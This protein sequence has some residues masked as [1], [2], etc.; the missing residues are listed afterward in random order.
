M[1][2]TN[3]GAF[4]VRIVTLLLISF[5]F[6][7]SSPAKSAWHEASSEHFVIYANQSPRT[8]QLFAERLEK[9]HAAMAFMLGRE[10]ETP[11]HPTG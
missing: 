8:V 10:P 1:I 7:V 5:L 11:S 9:F 4:F 6:F 3:M 2:D